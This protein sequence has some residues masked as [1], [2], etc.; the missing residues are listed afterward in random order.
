MISIYLHFTVTFIYKKKFKPLL[1]F[2]QQCF[3][4]ASVSAVSCSISA[5]A[6]NSSWGL[7]YSA[8]RYF[9]WV[10]SGLFWIME[11]NQQIGSVEAQ[12]KVFE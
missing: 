11:S 5:F 8:I 6:L 10:T 12:I 7:C 2:Y 4:E 3:F 9:C 1:T